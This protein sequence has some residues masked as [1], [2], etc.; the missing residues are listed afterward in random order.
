MFAVAHIIIT[1]HRLGPYVRDDLVVRKPLAS[2]TMTMLNALYDTP[3][4][5]LLI[6]T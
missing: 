3:N 2:Y 4:A 6:F 5:L 1:P